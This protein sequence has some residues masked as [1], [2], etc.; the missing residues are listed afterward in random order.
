M[1]SSPPSEV[2]DRTA[3]LARRRFEMIALPNS[4]LDDSPSADERSYTLARSW[5]LCMSVRQPTRDRRRSAANGEAPSLHAVAILGTW[6]APCRRR[7][8]SSSRRSCLDPFTDALVDGV[9]DVARSAAVEPPTCV[10]LCSGRHAALSFIDSSPSTSSP[11]VELPLRR[12]PG[13][14]PQ[15]SL[16]RLIEAVPYKVH[17]VL[18]DKRNPLHRS[19]WRLAWS[20]VEIREMIAE[21]KP[22]RRACLRICLRHQ[23]MFDHRLD[24]AEASMDAMVRS[25]E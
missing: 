20:P 14:T 15:T 18:T 24:E 16:R 25:S 12:S 4:G 8:S 13:A 11:S 22:F 5:R 17:T 19:H 9:A 1:A 21:R 7:S 6:S 3:L 10:R 23:L 2:G